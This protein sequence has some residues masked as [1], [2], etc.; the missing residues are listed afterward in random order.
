MLWEGEC[1]ENEIQKEAEW[2]WLGLYISTA[3]TNQYFGQMNQILPHQSKSQG[4]SERSLTL[5]SHYFPIPLISLRETTRSTIQPHMWHDNTPSKW[6]I[7]NIKSQITH[8]QHNYSTYKHD[9]VTQQ[10]F[11]LALKSLCISQLTFI[12]I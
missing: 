2:A 10:K 5:S 9:T 6:E 11:P 12:T 4:I 3:K 8:I 7:R 1:V